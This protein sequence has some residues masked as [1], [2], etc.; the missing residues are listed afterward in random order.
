MMVQM[1]KLVRQC[2]MEV[3]KMAMLKHEETFK[4]QV[5]YIS[6]KRKPKITII[7]TAKNKKKKL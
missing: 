5:R 3:M 7:I 2:D 6:I 1:E 4:Q